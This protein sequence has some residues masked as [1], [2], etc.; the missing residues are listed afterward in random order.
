MEETGAAWGL[1]DPDI[2]QEAPERARALG[3]D[4]PVDASQ[5]V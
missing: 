2:H 4:I 5:A 1:S 3:S